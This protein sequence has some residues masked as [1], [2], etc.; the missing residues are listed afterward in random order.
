MGISFTTPRTRGVLRPSSAYHSPFIC[1]SSAHYPPALA[2]HPPIIRFSCGYHPPI[3]RT[4]S[5]HHLPLIHPS[6]ANRPPIIRPSSVHHPPIICRSS[7]H[8]Y[9]FQDYIITD[10]QALE[11]RNSEAV[12]AYIAILAH[13]HSHGVPLL[14]HIEI[15]RFLERPAMEQ[16][17]AKWISLCCGERNGTKLLQGLQRSRRMVFPCNSCGDRSRIATR[18]AEHSMRCR[19]RRRTFEEAR[20]L[21]A[22]S[23]AVSD[24]PLD[25]GRGDDELDWRE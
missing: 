18:R 19:R 6:F 11:T 25:P 3:F 22:H 8:I 21:L 16:G 24:M 17:L 4:L 15:P 13:V 20:F 2:H 5:S 14:Q 7:A 23:A 12:V 10:L 1:P 9:F